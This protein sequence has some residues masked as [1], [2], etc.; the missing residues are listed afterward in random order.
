MKTELIQ[1]DQ[2]AAIDHALDILNNQGLIA[3]PT[4]TVYGLAAQAFNHRTI[5]SLYI[6][7]GRNSTR[8]IAI[9]IGR[10]SDL[11]LVI[12]G[13]NPLAS[14]LAAQFW[15]GPITLVVPGS[16]KLPNNVSPTALIGVRMP[17]HPVAL[18]LLRRSGPL[19]VTSA[20]LSGAANTTTAKDVMR[21][22]GGRIH[23][24][25][26]GGHTPGGIPSTVVDCSSSEP[27]ILREGPITA[28]QVHLVRGMSP[29]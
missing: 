11:D 1:A 18:A 23:L 7:K 4:D 15:P 21:Q 14:K 28:E 13:M 20:N 29:N 26:D 3:F 25:L 27:I 17:N 19:A 10:L 24:I 9:L 12:A 16:A 2:P 5:E 22:L 8:A 6:V